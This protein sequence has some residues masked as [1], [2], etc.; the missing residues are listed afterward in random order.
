MVQYSVIKEKKYFALTA[1]LFYTVSI[2][3]LFLSY[4][5]KKLGIINSL[6][7][8]LGI[9]FVILIGRL[10][11]NE[12]IT[13]NEYIGIFF[14][15]IGILIIQTKHIINIKWIEDN[16]K[17]IENNVSKYNFFRNKAT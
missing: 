15:L 14:I 11:F 6:V 3:F 8:G 7:G 5:Y 13:H 16:V 1:L 10:F 4:K 9:I 12:K 17:L 2:Y